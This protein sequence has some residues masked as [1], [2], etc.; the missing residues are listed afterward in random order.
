MTQK[1]KQDCC[2]E[3]DVK[4]RNIREWPN[5]SWGWR[6]CVFWG[7]YVCLSII[8]P[9]HSREY[10][11]NIWREF[12]YICHKHPLMADGQRS[13]SELKGQWVI[14]CTQ[15][16]KGQLHDDIMSYWWLFNTIAHRRGDCWVSCG[17]SVPSRPVTQ[18]LPLSRS[19]PPT[20]E[21]SQ[22]HVREPV[23]ES[24]AA[25]L[26]NYARANKSSSHHPHISNPS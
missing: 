15:T 24:F 19:V 8:C 23:R 10:L 6:F 4:D 17:V 7:L 18:D 12:C 22:D 9:S 16:V 25:Y 13:K 2:F 11:R 20:A 14:F 3:T 5:D 21:Q 1:K 26:R